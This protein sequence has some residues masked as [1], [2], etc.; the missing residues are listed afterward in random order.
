MKI[1]AL[2]T[3]YRRFAKCCRAIDAILSQTRPVDEIIVI[4]NASPEPEY[5]GLHDRYSDSPVPVNVV[6]LSRGTHTQPPF[7]RQD[8]S[9]ICLH[10]RDTTNVAIGLAR[11]DWLAFC[12]DDDEW[13][14]NR[15][16]SQCN[17]VNKH[18]ACR[19]FGCNVLNRNEQGD[20]LEIGR[21]HV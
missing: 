1:S 8:G 7:C 12:H 11:G 3:T 5:R 9:E 14:P 21:A 15:I 4:D 16:E 17:A 19:V 18:S 20:V 6:R 13:M 10:A 2:V